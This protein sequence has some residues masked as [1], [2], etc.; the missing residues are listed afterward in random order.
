MENKQTII[1]SGL[2]GYILFICGHGTA[3]LKESFAAN[4]SAFLL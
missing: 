1:L 2:Y 3:V 4:V